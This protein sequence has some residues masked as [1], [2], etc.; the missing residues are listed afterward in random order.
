MK[1][2]KNKGIT[3]VALVITIVII[4]IL[5]TIAINFT[6]G[7]NGLITRAQQA[8]EMS[9][10][11]RILEQLEMAKGSAYI[12]GAG[13]IDP[14]H[15]FDI[16]EEEGIINDKETDVVDNGDGSYD[17]TT[18]GDRVCEVTLEPDGD[19]DIEYVGKNNEPR[20]SSIKV[21]DKTENSISV[22]VVTKNVDNAEYTYSYKKTDEGE[23]AWQEAGKSNTNTFTFKWIR[24]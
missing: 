14:D 10:V 23:E 18:E 21:T 9:E 15:Y 17:V 5:S 20:I 12:D 2:L 1:K 4:I 6:F 19:L 3:L 7:E 16:L 24:E 22:E 11:S 13:D 8:A